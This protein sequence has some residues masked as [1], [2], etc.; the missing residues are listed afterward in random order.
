MTDAHTA[1]RDGREYPVV[2]VP[3]IKCTYPRSKNA[4][5]TMFFECCLCGHRFSHEELKDNPST[6]GTIGD[7][8]VTYVA[9]DKI[10]IEPRCDITATTASNITVNIRGDFSSWYEGKKT[11]SKVV[12][13]ICQ[14]YLPTDG[15]PS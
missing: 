9:G 14:K 7:Y 13:E 1:F 3:C 2:D 6:T 10:T 4:P 5:A 12:E 15:D 8:S 11:A